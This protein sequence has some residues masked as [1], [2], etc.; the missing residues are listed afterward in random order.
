MT[1]SLC[2]LLLL[3][4]AS[5]AAAITNSDL[6][7]GWT[8]TTD[9]TIRYELRWQ[10]YANGW[11]WQSIATNLD[12]TVGSYHFVYPAPFVDSVGDRGLCV[13]ARATQGIKTPSPWLS[14][15][16]NSQVCVQMPLAAAP[17]P[18]P[19][20]IPPPP[21][22][23][24]VPVTPPVTYVTDPAVLARLA[25]VEAAVGNLSLND[26]AMLN[27]LTTAAAKAT[28]SAVKLDAIKQAVCKLSTSSTLRNALR[29]A[30]GA[31]GCV[32]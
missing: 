24:P 31:T 7:V 20:P 6:T 13:D 17:T 27:T 18:T 19:V 21:A 10:T 16:N 26:Q 32:K 22:P 30:L 3:L 29:T 25:A 15:T 11:V 9:S 1:R 12:S 23:V 8:P 28:D 2:V 5:S 14:E 4:Y